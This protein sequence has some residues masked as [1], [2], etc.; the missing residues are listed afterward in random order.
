LIN[1]NFQTSAATKEGKFENQ[2]KKKLR[3]GL[4]VSPREAGGTNNAEYTY[5]PK[6]RR[7]N[8]RGKKKKL[9]RIK[10]GGASED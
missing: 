7:V 2:K 1:G 5:Q 10:S 6:K 8:E 3:L 4:A 9:P